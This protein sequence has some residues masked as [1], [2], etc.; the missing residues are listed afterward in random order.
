[1]FTASL[2][3]QIIMFLSYLW[4]GFASVFAKTDFKILS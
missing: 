1:M 4:K 3:P 2:Y